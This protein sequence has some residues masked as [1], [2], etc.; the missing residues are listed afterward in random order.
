MIKIQSVIVENNKEW[1]EL[2][3]HDGDVVCVDGDSG[4]GK[5]L[6]LN[7]LLNLYLNDLAFCGKTLAFVPQKPT[8]F[9]GTIK[10]NITLYRDY[11]DDRLEYLSNMFYFSS[12]DLNSMLFDQGHPLSGG[13]LQRLV[14]IR[15]LLCEPD[16][17]I[18][19]EITSAMDLSLAKKIHNELINNSS[20]LIFTSHHNDLKVMSNKII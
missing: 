13:E 12:M 4:S 3:L 15:A 1:P 16:V 5:S 14:V 2:I 8:T 20:N 19:D 6:Y 9:C 18:A 17:I 7:K 10:D 11:S